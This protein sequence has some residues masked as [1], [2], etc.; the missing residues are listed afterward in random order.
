MIMIILI[1]ILKA[2]SRWGGWGGGS[3]D[4]VGGGT[5]QCEVGFGQSTWVKRS[6]RRLPEDGVL[7][8]KPG[9]SH[10]VGV[11]LR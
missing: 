5:S 9:V 4:L 7:V 1:I 3:P 10:Y 11:G 8:S 2:F 6:R